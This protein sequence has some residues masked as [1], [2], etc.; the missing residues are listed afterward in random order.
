[1]AKTPAPDK[2]SLGNLL[3]VPTPR[4]LSIQPPSRVKS[5]TEMLRA[6][7]AH[8]QMLMRSVTSAMPSHIRFMEDDIANIKEAIKVLSRSTLPDQVKAI[9]KELIVIKG[10]ITDLTKEVAKNKA[11]WEQELASFKESIETYVKEVHSEIEIEARKRKRE[12]T[13][14]LLEVD[15]MRSKYENLQSDSMYNI[16]AIKNMA[17]MVA[18]LVENARIQQALEF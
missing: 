9:E 14:L 16:D 18:C 17:E 1:M 8:D 12:R 5:D 10:S 2:R 15:T 13:D 7:S 6:E 4:A 11:E 3:S